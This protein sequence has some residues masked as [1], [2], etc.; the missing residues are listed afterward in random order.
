MRQ[1]ETNQKGR[2]LLLGA[3]RKQRGMPGDGP[4]SG[5]SSAARGASP[6]PDFR[7]RAGTASG[8]LVLGVLGWHAA[9]AVGAQ[10]VPIF[11]N[12]YT[13]LAGTA[14][15]VLLAFIWPR[16][17]KRV[18]WTLAALVMAALLVV[19]Y[20]RYPTLGVKG[21]V[22]EDPLERVEAVV[23][24]SSE[25]R[26][27]GDLDGASRARLLHGFEVL[28]KGYA[29]ELVLTRLP[30]PRPSYVPA[31]RKLMDNLGLRQ[32]ILETGT[33]HNTHDEAVEVRKLAR[34]RGWKKVILVSDP[35]HMRRAA[36][37]FRK[38]GLD[39]ICSPCVQP[40]FHPYLLTGAGERYRAFTT[41]LWEEVGYQVYRRRGWL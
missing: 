23:V 6:R 20:T 13:V 36:A 18:G 17:A 35:T 4:K 30:H 25:I 21:L 41:W 11:R 15:A 28:G 2:E 31:V 16:P 34:D 19:G 29:R 39:V 26:K 7:E 12:N 37:T 9:Y 10:I 14:I 24:L 3:Q 33:V 8:G 32:R 1:T 5:K 27:N 22:R 38:Q 40:D